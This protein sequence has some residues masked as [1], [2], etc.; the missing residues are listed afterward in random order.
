M[1]EL[2]PE[3]TLLA[4]QLLDSISDILNKPKTIEAIEERVRAQH[5][6]FVDDY[7]DNPITLLRICDHFGISILKLRKQIMQA[8]VGEIDDFAFLVEQELA[9]MVHVQTREQAVQELRMGESVKLEELIRR[10]LHGRKLKQ[11]KKAQRE[12]Q[13]IRRKRPRTKNEVHRH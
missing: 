8:A 5:F 4:R 12:N 10:K 1:K 6:L 13:E 2:S 3:E 11:S 9:D 7:R